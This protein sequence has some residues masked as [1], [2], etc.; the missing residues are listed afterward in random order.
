MSDSTN[1][2]SRFVAVMFFI[3]AGAGVYGVMTHSKLKAAEDRLATVEQERTTLKDKLAT[4][5]KSV[6]EK[7]SA[8]Q[9][10]TAE[11]EGFKSRAEAAESALESAKGKKST[12]RPKAG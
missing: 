9:T 10:C 5:E 3:A 1:V 6:T 11:L 8:A 7:T 4:S 2:L 12:A